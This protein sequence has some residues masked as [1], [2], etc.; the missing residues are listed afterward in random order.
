MQF[1][2][3]AAVHPLYSRFANIFGASLFGESDAMRG[4]APDAYLRELGG[5]EQRGEHHEAMHAEARL[6]EGRAV[7]LPCP[8]RFYM[9]FSPLWRQQVTVQNDRRSD[10]LRLG[11]PGS[12]GPHTHRVVPGRRRRRP[13][14]RRGRGGRGRAVPAGGRTGAGACEARSWTASALDGPWTR[15]RRRRGA[16]QPRCRC[17]VPPDPTPAPAPGRSHNATHCISRLEMIARV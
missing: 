6:D 4:S 9:E 5:R 2:V 12:K 8:V 16:D 10:G 7:M 1:A 17:S 15:R 3:C 13:A 14:A 11:T